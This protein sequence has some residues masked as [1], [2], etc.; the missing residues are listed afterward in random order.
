MTEDILWDRFT[1]SGHR[2]LHKHPPYTLAAAAGF[3][4][5]EAPQDTLRKA[6]ILGWKKD[7]VGCLLRCLKQTAFA[8]TYC[9]GTKEWKW[10]YPTGFWLGRLAMLGFLALSGVGL[11]NLWR[12]ERTMSIVLGGQALYAAIILFPVSTES[13]YLVPVYLCL[14]PA[15]AAGLSIL[16]RKLPRL[17]I[18]PSL[19]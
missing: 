10:R 2:D 12:Q 15:V 1:V 14:V 3:L 6:A 4:F 8:W 18:N 5:N 17:N 7:P 9:P 13:R 19:N 11:V 16:I